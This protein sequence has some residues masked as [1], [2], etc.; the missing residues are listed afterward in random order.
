MRCFH[1]A[2]LAAF[3]S[4]SNAHGSAANA[5]YDQLMQEGVQSAIRKDPQKAVFYF[6][7]AIKEKPNDSK[8]YLKRAFQYCWLKKFDEAKADY[9]MAISIDPKNAKIFRERG[10]LFGRTRRY[11]DAIKDF[12]ESIR[13]DPKIS[14]PYLDRARAYQALGQADK[15]QKDIDA[16]LKFYSGKEKVGVKNN[17]VYFT[18]GNNK[19]VNP[20][21]RQ[22]A[23]IGKGLV[24]ALRG[25][26]SGAAGD[27]DEALLD[28][29]Q[30]AGMIRNR[31][32]RLAVK[33]SFNQKGKVE[34]LIKSY[35]ELIYL[36][37]KDLDSFYNR[38]IVYISMK[39][40]D[41]AATNFARVS[42]LAKWNGKAAVQASIW[43][44]IGL[45]KM[46][47]KAE[48]DKVV[49]EAIANCRDKD[50]P[51]PLLC[52]LFGIKSKD[53]ILK[54]A[55]TLEQKTQAHCIVG[56]KEGLEGHKSESL[57]HYEWIEKY[58]DLTVDEFVIALNELPN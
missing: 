4:V 12:T 10:C 1:C 38:G 36:N 50:W 56:L 57:R 54:D 23:R 16:A 17:Q 9:D 58:G 40:W 29:N 47:K 28:M 33:K 41:S 2:V 11:E 27:L 49:S 5:Q 25:N 46:N 42:Y 20:T 18:Y 44:C 30:S 24:V 45:R 39:Q 26:I 31:P 19:T 34:K 14:T 32:D 48:A 13:L 51:Y 37:P 15:A 6:S 55:R 3:L 21:Q 43:R 22:L 52:F 35:S 8:A 7:K 53:E